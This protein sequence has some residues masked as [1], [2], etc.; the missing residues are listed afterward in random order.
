MTNAQVVETEVRS[1]T[2]I[3]TLNRPAKRN[4]IDM[5]MTDLIDDAL[6]LL[7]DDADL[8]VAVLTSSSGY[9]SAGTDLTQQASP[10]SRR[11]GEYGLARRR[12]S[13]PVIAAVDGDALGGGFE[14][15]LACDIVVAGEQVRFSLPE[16]KRGVV[17]NSGGLFRAVDRLGHSLAAEMLLTGEP[18]SVQRA[19]Q[20]GLVN[21][22]VAP[23]TA[24]DA[25]IRIADRIALN[26][27]A[28][29]DASMRALDETRA[30]EDPWRWEITRTAQHRI[31]ESSDHL[32]GIAAF[33]AKRTPDWYAAR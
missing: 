18:L 14:L 17:A 10:A 23:G 29:L 1:R 32:E 28:A 3:I 8:R 9:F 20:A 31:E 6:A 5:E 21:T 4:A 24:L 25:A 22:I 16:V 2:L 33:F 12:R 7:E 15:V 26:S 13:K 30:V 11:G 19:H 27:P